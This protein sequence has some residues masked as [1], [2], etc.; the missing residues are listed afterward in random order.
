M[1]RGSVRCREKEEPHSLPPLLRPRS[2]RD[3]AVQAP[4]WGLDLTH[5]RAPVVQRDGP[6]K[7]PI[8]QART[9]LSNSTE[10]P[11][12]AAPGPGCPP[13]QPHYL[14]DVPSSAL[15]HLRVCRHTAPT[16]WEAHPSFRAPLGRPQGGRGA[17]PPCCHSTLHPPSHWP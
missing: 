10:S 3:S 9:E 5:V 14:Q 15:P 13:L 11:S 8:W 2:C 17:P 12:M 4:S 6:E 7:D 16:A 1:Q